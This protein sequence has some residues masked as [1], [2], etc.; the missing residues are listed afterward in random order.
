M[1]SF[2]TDILSFWATVLRTRLEVSLERCAEAR[3]LEPSATRS[4]AQQ[5]AEET[6]LSAVR[7]APNRGDTVYSSGSCIAGLPSVWANHAAP[8]NRAK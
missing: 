3:F 6:S 4:D 8:D 5:H 7:P 2:A 1:E